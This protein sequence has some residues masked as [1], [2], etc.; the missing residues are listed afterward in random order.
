MKTEERYRLIANVTDAAARELFH[1][2]Y[3]YADQTREDLN[4]VRRAV[5]LARWAAPMAMALG[6]FAAGKLL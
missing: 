2:L 1:D 5:G 3:G 6:I 4:I